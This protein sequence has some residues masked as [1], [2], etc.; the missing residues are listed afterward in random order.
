[1]TRDFRRSFRDKNFR[2]PSALDYNNMTSLVFSRENRYSLATEITN[3]KIHLFSKKYHV[4][5]AS[6]PNEIYDIFCKKYGSLF[7][8]S[9]V[10]RRGS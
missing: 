8:T 7:L 10:A 2:V 3:Q 6:T 1:M 9:A 4:E 5:G